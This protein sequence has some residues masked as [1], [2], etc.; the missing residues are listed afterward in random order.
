MST[1]QPLSSPVVA[2]SVPVTA[3]RVP[4]TLMSAISKLQTPSSTSVPLSVPS[5]PAV[6]QGPVTVAV[7]TTPSTAPTPLRHTVQNLLAKPPVTSCEQPKVIP[8]SA[9]QSCSQA[10]VTAGSS[11]Q[12]TASTAP[13]STPEQL[14]Q[15]II[16]VAQERE[17][18][19]EKAK[20]AAKKPHIVT[21]VTSFSSPGNTAHLSNFV[22]K[23]L[24][25][26]TKVNAISHHHPIMAPGFHLNLTESVQKVMKPIPSSDTTPPHSPKTSKTSSST[27]QATVVSQVKVNKG[28]NVSAVM[29]RGASPV[30]L[31]E[32]LGELKSVLD[33]KPPTS[34]S[35]PIHVNHA[36]S[37]VAVH[38]R[39]KTPS[40]QPPPAISALSFSQANSYHRAVS[41]GAATN[42][43]MSPTM[44]HTS[45]QRIS[46]SLSRTPSPRATPQ[47]SPS[48]TNYHVSPPRSVPS[49]HLE[50]RKTPSPASSVAP[51]IPTPPL[52]MRASP[53][54]ISQHVVPI[55]CPV[56]VDGLVP[57]TTVI[58]LRPTGV[59]GLV[60]EHSYSAKP[61]L[62]NHP[63]NA[64][65]TVTVESS[66]EV[67]QTKQV[68]VP[69]KP[70][71]LDLSSAVEVKKP[72]FGSRIHNVGAA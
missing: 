53:N 21:P 23:S 34:S 59:S 43:G 66:A 5:H 38:N 2:S 62:A 22:Q 70:R 49:P 16:K 12:N 68:E 25:T 45:P 11:S 10:K 64:V 35:K 1:S 56:S 15:S 17:K 69:R 18:A 6:V 65:S 51:K 72:E 20:S 36:L 54:K 39:Q 55:S 42:P 37:P 19:A 3:C 41:P 33:S 44:I 63:P 24:N 52:L 57:A 13:T 29:S 47:L 27:S 14:A 67:L 61:V 31:P 9:P 50:N 40:P 46:P 48:R 32:T 30:R 28:S 7:R 58:T 8:T 4:V 60:G 71:V 26:P